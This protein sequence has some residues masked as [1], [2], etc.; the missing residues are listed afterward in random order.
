MLHAE[1]KKQRVGQP[2]AIGLEQVQIQFQPV[3]DDYMQGNIE[4]DEMKEK[5]EWNKRWSWDFE[6]YKGVFQTAR[7]LNIRLL[8]LNV[9]SEDLE[10]VEKGGYPGLPLERLRKYIQDP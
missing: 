5:V 4:L 7:D 10:K 3:L 8:A 1:R 2:M 6:G 9:D